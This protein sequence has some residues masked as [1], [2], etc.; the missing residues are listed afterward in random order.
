VQRD[1]VFGRFD[2]R[3]LLAQQRDQI[4]P[5]LHRLVLRGQRVGGFEVVGL[6][7]EDLVV[8]VDDHHIELQTI[9]IDLD[10]LLEERDLVLGRRPGGLLDRLLQRLDEVVPALRLLVQ[11]GERLARRPRLRRLGDYFFPGVDSLVDRLLG[12]LVRRLRFA[13]QLGRKVIGNAVA[14]R[15]RGL[16]AFLPLPVALALALLGLVIHCAPPDVGSVPPVCSLT[17]MC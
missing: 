10:H 13:G 3:R 8:G 17:L 12:G 15:C 6:D 5:A 1:L 9:A 4:R 14:A 16:V 2:D 7:R 11:I